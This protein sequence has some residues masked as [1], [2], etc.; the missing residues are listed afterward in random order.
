MKCLITS[1]KTLIKYVLF[2]TCR[3]RTRRV[4]CKVFCIQH[5]F[6]RWKRGACFQVILLRW[7]I[8]EERARLLQG[9]GGLLKCSV[10][11]SNV[12]SV[13]QFPVL[14]M[15]TLNGGWVWIYHSSYNCFYYLWLLKYCFAKRLVFSKMHKM[16]NLGLYF[17][18][19]K[20]NWSYRIVKELNVC[21]LPLCPSISVGVHTEI[22]QGFFHD[23]KACI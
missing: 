14:Q 9:G 23:C 2:V 6:M 13:L 17:I 10:I 3:S 1:Y 21:L 18:N 4:T 22:T 11:L 20:V 5:I 15:Y 19:F 8:C 16:G 12:Y 7:F